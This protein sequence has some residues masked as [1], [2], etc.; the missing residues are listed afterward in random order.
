MCKSTHICV[1][2]RVLVSNPPWHFTTRLY[3]QPQPLPLINFLPPLMQYVLQYDWDSNTC[4]L[5]HTKNIPLTTKNPR[6][7]EP[8]TGCLLS[9]WVTKLVENL[10]FQKIKENN[11]FKILQGLCCFNALSSNWKGISCVC[12]LSVQVEC[13]MDISAEIMK[14]IAFYQRTLDFQ[15]IY[16][17]SFLMRFCFKMLYLLLSVVW[18]STSFSQ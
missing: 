4:S 5:W 1:P 18:T 6:K 8:Q 3:P 7:P 12:D 11:T 17:S 14:H 15:F 9:I 2:P 13:S 16:N 10:R